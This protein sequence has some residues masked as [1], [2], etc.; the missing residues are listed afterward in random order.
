MLNGDALLP[1]INANLAASVFQGTLQKFLTVTRGYL[2]VYMN[3]YGSFRSQLP[4]AFFGLPSSQPTSQ[5]SR[6][7]SLQPTRQPIS[8][9]TRQ[10][11]RQP[12][13]QPTRQPTRQPTSQ[14]TRQPT[15]QPTSQPTLLPT[16]TPKSFCQYV[17]F[18]SLSSQMN[19]W[20]YFTVPAF[21][22]PGVETYYNVTIVASGGLMYFG[23]DSFAES[24]ELNS[25]DNWQGKAFGPFTL[26]GKGGVNFEFYP[27]QWQ[28]SFSAMVCPLRAVP[29]TMPTPIPIGKHFA[30]QMTYQMM[31]IYFSSLTRY[32]LPLFSFSG[33]GCRAPSCVCN[34]FVIFWHVQQSLATEHKLSHV[35]FHNST[36]VTAITSAIIAS[37]NSYCTAIITTYKS[38]PGML[39]GTKQWFQSPFNH[40]CQLS[41]WL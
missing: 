25:L 38:V 14:P 12:T 33:L 3:N 39:C 23:S 13:S 9:P 36:D 2:N 7:P 8:H 35:C 20:Q 32:F 28:A 15:R 21:G 31:L 30:N 19:S 6:Q 18:M 11:T 22:T 26:V 24:I 1:V 4:G 27:S 40:A 41:V 37:V 5:P 17:S 10:P 34:W 16:N 29:S